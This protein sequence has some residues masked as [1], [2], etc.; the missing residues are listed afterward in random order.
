MNE[1][2]KRMLEEEYQKTL[3]EVSQATAGSDEAKWRLQK[4]TELHKQ[5]MEEIQIYVTP[6]MAERLD[7]VADRERRTR[8]QQAARLVEDGVVA[9]EN[10]QH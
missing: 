9:N 3:E 6:S 2:M 7:R 1:T 8:T 4:L 10:V 5:M